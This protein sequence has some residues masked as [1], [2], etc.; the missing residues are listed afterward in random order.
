LLAR[1]RFFAVIV[2][3]RGSAVTHGHRFSVKSLAVN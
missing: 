2:A 3:P 1:G